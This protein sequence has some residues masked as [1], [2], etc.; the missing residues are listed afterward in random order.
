MIGGDF[1]DALT[2]AREAHATQ[3]RKGTEIPYIAHLLAVAALVLEDGG[4]EQEVIAA[5]L[6]DAIEDGGGEQMRQRIRGRFDGRVAAI[7]AA[8]TDTDKDPKPAWRERKK[9]Y[10]RHLR[11]DELPAGTLRV[12]LADKLHNLRA[13]LT[14]LREVGGEVWKR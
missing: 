1:D 2:I 13:I 3:K 11:H 12:S 4:D 9:H 8:C 6:H 14:D 5:L 10:L 7:V